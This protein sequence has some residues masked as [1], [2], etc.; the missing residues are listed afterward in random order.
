VVRFKTFSELKEAK[1][2]FVARRFILQIILGE[3]NKIILQVREVKLDRPFESMLSQL[4]DYS[5]EHN[6]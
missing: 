1:L 3:F 5:M 6:Y 4:Q 2:F